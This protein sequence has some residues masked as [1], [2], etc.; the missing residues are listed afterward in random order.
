MV[1]G[2]IDYCHATALCDAAEGGHISS[3]SFLLSKGAHVDGGVSC[4]VIYVYK[5]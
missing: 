3:V 4:E 5:R 1:V 2:G